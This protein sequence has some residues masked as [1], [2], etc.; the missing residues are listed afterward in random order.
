MVM[1]KSCEKGKTVI[2]RVLTAPCPDFVGTSLS[3]A[4]EGR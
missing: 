4:G 1:P 2:A 3:F